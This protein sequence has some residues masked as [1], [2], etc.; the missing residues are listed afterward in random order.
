MS[1]RLRQDDPASLAPH[2]RCKCGFKCPLL[3]PYQS[4]C[5]PGYFCPALSTNLTP[6]P[7]G[8]SC[9]DREMC[10]P[11]PCPAGTYQETGSQVACTACPPGTTSPAA[12]TS[13]EQCAAG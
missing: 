6:C 13:K 1:G 2:C 7:A 11:L 3:A 8:H 9:P 4:A 10:A 12:A 5:V